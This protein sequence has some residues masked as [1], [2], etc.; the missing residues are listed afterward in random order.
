MTDKTLDGS[1]S[2]VVQLRR[3]EGGEDWTVAH[4]VGETSDYSAVL[5]MQKKVDG[6]ER[7]TGNSILVSVITC[8]TI[9]QGVAMETG[10][11]SPQYFDACTIIELH[12]DDFKALGLGKNTNVKVTSAVGSVVLKAVETTQSLY[13]GLAHIPMGPWANILVPAYTYSTGEPCFKGFDCTVEP[14]PQERILGAVELMRKKC[15]LIP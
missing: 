11:T 5:E 15:G 14:A 12:P 13:P 6:K 1:F 7:L 10:K 2:P 3:T 8:R 9:K 4:N